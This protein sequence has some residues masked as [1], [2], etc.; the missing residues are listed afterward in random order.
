MGKGN[1]PNLSGLGAGMDMANLWFWAKLFMGTQ[2][3]YHGYSM[4]AM[5]TTARGP[6]RPCPPMDR[7]TKVMDTDF[8]ARFDL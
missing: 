2:N 1:A 8:E 4:V 6:P 5:A 3:S 7:A